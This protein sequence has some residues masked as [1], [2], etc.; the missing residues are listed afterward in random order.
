MRHSAVH[1]QCLFFVCLE[2]LWYL[3][4]LISGIR[5]FEPL[6]T[7]TEVSLEQK[8]ECGWADP[9]LWRH[10]NLPKQFWYP[11]AGS[12]RVQ[13]PRYW[14]HRHVYPTGYRSTAI[15]KAGHFY[16]SH[17]DNMRATKCQWP[18]VHCNSPFHLGIGLMWF[19]KIGNN[20]EN[21]TRWSLYRI[22][23]KAWCV[24]RRAC[25]EGL[26]EEFHLDVKLLAFTRAGDEFCPTE[27]CR[28][29][30]L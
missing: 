9:A 19:V 28:P 2:A 24:S 15:S 14:R 8:Q 26:L 13:N 11:A 25:R 30:W 29:M 7:E 21:K 18:E 5:S 12:A 16:K 23:M 6:W 22:V 4:N 10:L 3:D 17:P 27:L 1:K 20:V